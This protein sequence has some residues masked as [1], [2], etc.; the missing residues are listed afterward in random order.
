MP[1]SL[2][3]LAAVLLML[4]QPAIAAKPY[5]ADP[6]PCAVAT[7]TQDWLDTA[8]RRPVPIKLYYPKTSA[9]PALSSSSPTAWAAPATAMNTWAAIGPA[10]A[11]SPCI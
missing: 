10:T 6:G 7:L 3:L 9:A 2:M 4:A 1:Q 8:R 5:T 11:M